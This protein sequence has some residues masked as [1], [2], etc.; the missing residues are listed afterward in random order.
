MKVTKLIREYVEESVAKKFAP[1]YEALKAQNETEVK[2]EAVKQWEK[3][4]RAFLQTEFR[5]RFGN[6][7]S[8]AI[9]SSID[10]IDVSVSWRLEQYFLGQEELDN[11]ECELHKRQEQAVKDILIELELG[12]TKADLDRLLNGV[13]VEDE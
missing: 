8:E 2:K 5:A 11:K 4:M 7:Y 6:W 9:A 10:H 12:G 3:E 13:T 1:A